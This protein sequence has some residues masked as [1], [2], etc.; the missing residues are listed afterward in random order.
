MEVSERVAGL[1]PL[2]CCYTW[3]KTACIYQL[4]VLEVRGLM[5]AWLG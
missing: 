2:G 1:V 3:L 4:S 5:W